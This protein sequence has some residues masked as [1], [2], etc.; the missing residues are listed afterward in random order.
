MLQIKMILNIIEKV[1][2]GKHFIG[3]IIFK[4]KKELRKQELHYFQNGFIGIQPS[5]Q[6]PEFV[7]LSGERGMFKFL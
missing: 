6:D 2:I 3:I 4:K 5:F 1:H 7:D